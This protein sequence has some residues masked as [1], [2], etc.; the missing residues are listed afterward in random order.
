[1]LGKLYNNVQKNETGPLL[2]L[3]TK[4]NSKWKKDVNV[5]HKNM[6]I[7][8][9]K[10]GSNLSDLSKS[11]LLLDSSPKARKM[12]S[13]INYQDFIRIKSFCT[14]KETNKTKRQLTEWEKI[15]ANSIS[16][17]GLVL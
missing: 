16:D 13:Y 8:E 14:T 6:K 9:E 2:I 5:R 10:T 15:L 11:T 1:M 7:L 3:Y 17:K 4:I 12:K